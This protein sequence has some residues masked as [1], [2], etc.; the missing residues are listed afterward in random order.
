VGEVEKLGKV[1]LGI[2]FVRLKPL[3]CWDGIG[4]AKFCVVLVCLNVRCRG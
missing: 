3:D 1:S 2:N 4:A